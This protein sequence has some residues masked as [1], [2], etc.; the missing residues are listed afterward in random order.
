[1]PKTIAFVCAKGGTGKTTLA[2]MF[3]MTLRLADRKVSID[4]RDPQQNATL[5]ARIN[6]L[7]IGPHAEDCVIIDTSPHIELPGTL[8]AIREADLVVLVLRPELYDLVNAKAT[9]K[10]IQQIRPPEAKTVMVFNQVRQDTIVSK[11]IMA[12][13]NEIPLPCLKST[14]RFSARYSRANRFGWRVLTKAEKEEALTFF[15]ELANFSNS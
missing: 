9:Y 6:D 15:I 12:A 8:A 14:I 10:V 2:V 5:G 1:M 13:K 11:D 3:A 4:D 7:P